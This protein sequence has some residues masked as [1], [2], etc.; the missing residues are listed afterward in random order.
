M[1][2]AQVANKARAREEASQPAASKQSSTQLHRLWQRRQAT[3]RQSAAGTTSMFGKALG[4][5][6]LLLRVFNNIA[7]HGIR[8]LQD[9][10]KAQP[11]GRRAWA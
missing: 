2:H 11:K 6:L 7:W 5:L 4:R 1:K 3:R 9:T 10:A 8:G